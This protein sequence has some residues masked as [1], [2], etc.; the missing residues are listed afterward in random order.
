MAVSNPQRVS[1]PH[2]TDKNTY[3]IPEVKTTTA[4]C[5]ISSAM[6]FFATKGWF[7]SSAQHIEIPIATFHKIIE[8][9][10][11]I[12]AETELRVSKFDPCTDEDNKKYTVLSENVRNLLK[13]F[14]AICYQNCSEK[15]AL[16]ALRYINSSLEGATI[17][18]VST[19]KVITITL[20]HG[21]INSKSL[22]KHTLAELIKSKPI[23]DTTLSVQEWDKFNDEVN[24]TVKS[25]RE[26][27]SFLQ[28]NLTYQDEEYPYNSEAKH[29][30]NRVQCIA[31][32]SPL[33][34]ATTECLAGIIIY[35]PFKGVVENCIKKLN[36]LTNVASIEFKTIDHQT[37]PEYECICVLQHKRPLIC[38]RL[39]LK[40]YQFVCNQQ[41]YD[42]LKQKYGDLIS[43]EHQKLMKNSIIYLNGA[44]KKITW[45]E[46]IVTHKNITR[47]ASQGSYVGT[48][49]FG[50]VKG[51][52]TGEITGASI[53]VAYTQQVK[54]TKTIVTQA[55]RWQRL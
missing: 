38:L 33:D 47:L 53:R 5:P 24:Y 54:K 23:T 26:A 20:N 25:S 51:T 34:E 22:C 40:G 35:P 9:Y 11:E 31:G 21:I 42:N 4:A 15:V 49:N 27:C 46:N 8:S 52:L 43:K 36:E 2:S 10:P 1:V 41:Y 18:R 29:L 37:K 28:T 17:S 12:Q 55:F 19:Q 44:E 3:V 6:A 50:G 16:K 39:Q 14:F 13:N 7:Y 45:T 30:M 32:L 48:F